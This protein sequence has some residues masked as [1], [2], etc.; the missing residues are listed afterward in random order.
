[1]QHNHNKLIIKKH[2]MKKKDGKKCINK[3][4]EKSSTRSNKQNKNNKCTCIN[5]HPKQHPDLPRVTYFYLHVHVYL[6]A[7]SESSNN[8]VIKRV[9]SG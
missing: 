6:T 7:A 3:K 8:Q 9:I 5:L 4:D 1:M 2:K